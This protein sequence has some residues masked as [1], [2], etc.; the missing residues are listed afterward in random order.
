MSAAPPPARRRAGVD[1][2]R[3]SRRAYGTPSFAT[4]PPTTQFLVGLL[5]L[6]LCL[7]AACRKPPATAADITVRID[8]EEIPYSDFESYL[9]DSIDDA[10][11]SL[12]GTVQ[13]QLFD[14]FLDAQL[15]IRLAIE[16]GLVQP[17]VNQRLAMEFL[18]RDDA[19]QVFSDDDLKA[20]YEAN[21][22]RFQR[23]EEVHLRQILVDDRAVAEQAQRA[24]RGG[25][26]FADVAARFSQ[27][28][29][30]SSGGDQ[31]RLA[32]EDLPTPFVDAIFDL[33][34]GEVT[35]IIS[36][37]YGFHIFQVVERFPAEIIPF[38]AV[39]NEIRSTL[40]RMDL[41]DRV[42]GFISEAR[43][44]YNVVV[45]PANFPFDYQGYYAQ[46]HTAPGSE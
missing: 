24:I 8:G 5:L 18:L 14:Q 35:D 16:R 33:E 11:S 45:F 12:L 34:P 28:P 41:D 36:A 39:E 10:D 30:A 31:G 20:Y 37:D 7:V 13:S 21:S 23:A 27:E 15:L 40:N 17:D 9:D 44:R 1:F 3:H 22:E 2:S 32:R 38:A 46:H 25:E 19:S 42:V 6:S 26:S 43:E 4:P 29:R